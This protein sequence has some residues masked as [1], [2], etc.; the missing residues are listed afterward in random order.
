M[1][2]TELDEDELSVPPAE[3]FGSSH[4]EYVTAAWGQT[5]GFALLWEKV[6]LINEKWKPIG[7]QNIDSYT[8]DLKKS[9]D[10]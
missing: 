5:L 4:E 6:L 9:N 7:M 2:L 10:K 3:V 8:S 1:F